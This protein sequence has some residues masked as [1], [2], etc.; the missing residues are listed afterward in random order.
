MIGSVTDST[1]SSQGPIKSLKVGRW[2]DS[3]ATRDWIISTGAIGSIT[4]LGDF[5]ADV[6]AT[7]LKSMN[8]R[9]GL[10]G[11][12]VRVSGNIGTVRAG[13]AN[14]S[15]VFAGVRSDVT[16]LPD[17]KD[18]F[19]DASAGIRSFSV[20]GGAFSNTLV[21][22]AS[23][24]RVLL[25]SVTSSNGGTPFGVAADTLRSLILPSLR[26]VN[27]SDPSASRNNA[28]FYARIL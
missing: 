15:R 5:G 16:T 6:T 4:S 1:L 28:D 24:G 22:A 26:L 2:L 12:D 11:S 25:G 9:G 20:V 8:V 18:D 13:S 27:G 7:A 3:D 10:V 19:V 21:A 23:I 14:G 17:G